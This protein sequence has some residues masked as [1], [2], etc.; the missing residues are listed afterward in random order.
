VFAAGDASSLHDH[1]LSAAMHEGNQAACGANWV[2]YDA[3]QR[4]AE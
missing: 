4:G 1:Q 2:L 3:D